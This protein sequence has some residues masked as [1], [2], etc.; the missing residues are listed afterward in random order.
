M[1]RSLR[2]SRCGE[3][4]DFFVR[5]SSLSRLVRSDSSPDGLAIDI[6]EK[7]PADY[8]WVAFH[9]GR[10]GHEGPRQDFVT[11]QV[12]VA[13]SGAPPTR[14]VE[15]YRLWSDNTWDTDFIAIP[16]N[17]PEG[18][19]TLNAA[20]NQSAAAIDWDEPPVVVGLY[21]DAADDLALDPEAPTDTEGEMPD[22][23]G[24]WLSD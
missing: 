22:E 3:R 2:C 4:K 24:A 14:Q 23:S 5:I 17:T 20:V 1:P 21:C 12:D 9:C 8:D 16:A 10:C 18:E 13:S 15:Y 6:S 11:S 19:E 7:T